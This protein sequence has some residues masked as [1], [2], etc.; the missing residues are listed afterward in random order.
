M[1]DLIHPMLATLVAEPF[2][3]AGWINEEKYDGIR[4][5]AYR[6][7]KRIR[8]FSRNL[9]ELTAEFAD[10]ADALAGLS[11]GDLVLDGEIVAFDSHDVSRFQILQRRALGESVTPVFAVFD[12]LELKGKPILKSALRSRREAVETLVPLGQGPLLPARRLSTNGLDAFKAAQAKGWEGIIAKDESSGYEPGV[13]SRS[14]LK[15]K[16]RK[17][18]EFVIGGYTAPEGRRRHFGALLVGLYDGRQLRF[19]GKVGTGYSA[20]VLADLAKKMA[21]LAAANSPFEPAPPGRGVTWLRPRLVAQIA[22]AE[23]T[24]DGKLRQPAFLGLRDDKRPADCQWRER[25][26]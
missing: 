24:Q 11:G 12:C 6:K 13:R 5:L 21:S 3:R 18:S 4:A 8:L 16:C 2:D 20:E 7:G 22:F 23:W 25:E 17:E 10:I 15:I 9:K 1:N 14:W 26:G 19:A